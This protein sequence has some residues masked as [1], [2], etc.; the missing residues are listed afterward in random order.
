MKFDVKM[1]EVGESISEVV[2]ARWLKKDGEVVD[3]DDLLCEIESDKASFEI[4]AEQSGVIS[5]KVSEGE[6]IPVGSLIAEIRADGQSSPEAKTT[7]PVKEAKPSSAK[8]PDAEKDQKIKIS[9]VA[10]NILVE[11]GLSADSVSGSGPGGRITKE[12]A[13]KAVEDIKTREKEA[14]ALAKEEES[15]PAVSPP[16]DSPQRHQCRQRV[17]P[18]QIRDHP[19]SPASGRPDHTESPHP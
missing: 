7:A 19:R 18:R 15:K 14:P 1:P 5:I 13:V 8:S 16:S 17:F 2:L 3:V 9:P 12:D 4:P 11:A 10:A 6:T